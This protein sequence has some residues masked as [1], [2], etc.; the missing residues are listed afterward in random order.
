MNA[1][2]ALEW[3]RKSQPE[4]ERWSDARAAALDTTIPV[5]DVQQAFDY[6]FGGMMP[7]L[8]TMPIGGIPY[9]EA[10]ASD[11]ELENILALH[12]ALDQGAPLRLPFKLAW[13][14]WNQKYG[15]STEDEFCLVL[16]AAEDNFEWKGSTLPHAI[17]LP[18]RVTNTQRWHIVIGC[19]A[20]YTMANPMF[21]CNL[22]RT[23]GHQPST[24]PDDG[25]GSGGDS[26]YLHHGRYP[27]VGNFWK[28]P[29]W[30]G[31]KEK[32]T[33]DKSYRVLVP[34]GAGHD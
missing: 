9:A 13:L 12:R 32:G 29:H 7:K 19:T 2:A 24:L 26:D 34:G 25:T 15:G 30:A 8:A 21:G 16:C 20:V 27:H 3:L 28:R 6:A 14:S 4:H 17:I 31:D 10:T 18:C 5:L 1:A 33:V 22:C 23:T 11:A